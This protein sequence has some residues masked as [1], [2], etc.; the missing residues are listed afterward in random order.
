[1]IPRTI[2]YCWFGD[3][4][5]PAEVL[6][7]IANW[8]KHCPGYEIKEWN[9]NNFDIRLNRYCEEAY[10]TKKWAFVSDV[11]RLW[12]LVHEGG[13]YMDTDVELVRPLDRLL[14]NKAF[15]GFE[16]TQWVGTNLIG[17]E[18]SHSFFIE[19][20]KSYDHR[21]F[22]TPDGKPDQTTNVEELT[23]KLEKVYGFRK[24]GSFQ[25]LGDITLYPTDYFCPYDYIDGQLHRTENTYSIHWYSQTWIKRSRW[26]NK[27][28]QWMHRLTGNRMMLFTIMN[29][30]GAETM[31]M[32]Y[33]RHIDRNRVQFD[34][35]VHRQERGA[36]D[37]EIEAMGGK[38]YRMIPLHPFT[39]NTYRKQISDFFDQHPEYR[40]IHGH[41]S[42]SGYFVY[43]EAA[44]R[45]VPVIIAHAHNAHALFDTKWLFRT[46]FKHTMRP[47][48][49]QG[50]T[51][52][53]EAA[54]WLFGNELGKKAILQRNAIDTFLYRFDEAVR[55][56]V[57][58][59]LHLSKD[60]TVVGHVGRFN[61]QKNHEF[62]LEVFHKYVQEFNPTAHLLLVGTGELQKAIQK[63]VQQFRLTDQVHL[64]GGRPDV[65]R[66]LQAMDLF[67]FPSFMEGLS[68]SMVEAQCAGLPCVVSDRIPREAAL[69]DQVSFLSL[70]TAP[71]QWACEIERVRCMASRRTGYYQQIADAGYDIVKNA[72][73]LQNYYL[74]QWN[75][76]R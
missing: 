48:L 10:A 22:I 30:G 52:G 73:W 13:V 16:G 43:R 12:A 65:N 59:E 34:F 5:K 49:T 1:M 51:C 72:E 57:R 6:R 76:T 28:S 23:R 66:L 71:R 9:E 53:K 14:T 32:N 39:F 7:M 11:A 35:M 24:D 27:L 31:V 47:Y 42:E 45:R 58:Q 21:C 55:L 70:E 60:V 44:G 25:Q 19:L 46:Y 37:D 15:L 75:K 26:I 36:Y 2:H 61:R 29:R 17:A 38:I 40:I 56:E 33:Y 20:L 18:P 3:K 68:V 64:L 74:G 41:C 50:F 8:Q 69:T 67:L 4:E 54:R 62:L 63:K